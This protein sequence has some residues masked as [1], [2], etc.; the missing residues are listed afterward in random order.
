MDPSLM[1]R[2]LAAGASGRG[3]LLFNRGPIEA[4]RLAVL[5]DDLGVIP[6]Y[7]AILLATRALRENARS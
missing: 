1:L 3:E 2:A 5:E 7:D 4:E 6:P